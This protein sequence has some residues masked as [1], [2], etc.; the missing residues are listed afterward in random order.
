MVTRLRDE[1]RGLVYDGLR[2]RPGGPCGDAFEIVAA[3]TNGSFRCTHGPD[4]APDGVDVR[5]PQAIAPPS[6]PALAAAE[7]G[8]PC[9]GT[10]SD[11]FRVQL[12]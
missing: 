1:R 6:A 8:I 3:M 5:F 7:A 11:G 10:G 4:P 12:L 2:Y 9:Y